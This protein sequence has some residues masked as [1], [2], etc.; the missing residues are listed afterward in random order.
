MD[1]ETA[2][3]EPPLGADRYGG[4]GNIEYHSGGRHRLHGLQRY[5]RAPGTASIYRRCHNRFL[6]AI[7][8]TCTETVDLMG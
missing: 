2:E 1:K 8:D 5:D 4:I 3:H 7:L 6:F